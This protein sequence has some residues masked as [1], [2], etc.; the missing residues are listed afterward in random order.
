MYLAPN[1]HRGLMLSR[2]FGLSMYCAVHLHRAPALSRPFGL[3]CTLP[4]TCIG[5]QRSQD[6]S[7]LPLPCFGLASGVDAL[8]TI[9]FFYVLCR[10]LALGS[11]AFKTIRSTMHSSANL[12]RALTLSKSLNSSITVLSNL[13]WGLMFSRPFDSSMCRPFA[14]GSNAFK[15]IRSA[16]HSS[17][18]MHRASAHGLASTIAY[19]LGGQILGLY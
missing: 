16:M 19:I 12:H 10:P 3:P 9:R 17:V 1:L 18:N 11:N 5:L 13:H 14:S 7:I 4:S 15:T 6:H 8:K 2:P